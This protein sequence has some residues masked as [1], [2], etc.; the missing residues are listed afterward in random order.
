M[1]ENMIAK[2]TFV[3][4]LDFSGEIAA[5]DM[6][7]A[8]EKAIAPIIGLIPN[9]HEKIVPAIAACEMQVPINGIRIPTI[10]TPK[11]PVLA[12]ATAPANIIK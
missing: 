2:P 9:R 12:P 4:S 11:R 10:Y 3:S 6:A 7:D 8:T 5:I 1:K